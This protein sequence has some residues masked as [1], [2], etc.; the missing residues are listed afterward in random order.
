MTDQTP[1]V[2]AK[3]RRKPA[4]KGLGTDPLD[5]IATPAPVAPIKPTPDLSTRIDP[6]NDLTPIA[7]DDSRTWETVSAA[8]ALNVL[9]NPITV[10]DE[11]YVIRY[12]NEAAYKMFELIEADIRRDLPHFRAREVVGKSVD[13]FHKNPAHQRRIMDGMTE[14][15]NGKFTV[16]GKHLGFRATP[17]FGTSG[18]LA[19]VFVEWKDLTAELEA[20]ASLDQ[21]LQA[22][23]DMSEAHEN[24][25][26]SHFINLDALSSELRSVAE[27]ANQMV[28]GHIATK[29]KILACMTEFANGNLDA[30]VEKFSGE[31]FFINDAIEAIRT[32]MKNVKAEVNKLTERTR[33]MAE[34]HANGIISSAIDSSDMTEEFAFV[35]QSTNK[36]VQQ[37]IETKKKILACVGQFAKGNF[38]APLEKFSGERFFINDTV[39]DIRGAFKKVTAEIERFC[40]A[41]DSGNLAIDIDRNGFDGSYRNIVDQM[42]N[43]LVSLNK[44][45]TTATQQVAQVAITVDQMSQ[46]SQSLA[47]NSQIA[48]S[49]VD[50]VSSSTEETSIQVK[51][52]ATAADAAAKLVGST[53]V[54]A[55]DG[56]QKITDM[57]A[58]MEGI[59]VSSQD[60]AKIIKVIDEIA[61][62]TN[63]L[64]LN[65]A[66]E[67]A[68]AGQHGRGFAVVAQEV[69]NLAGRSA[70]AARETSE[71]IEDAS[72][73]VQSGVRIAGEAR[74]SFT[75]IATDIQEVQSLV[76]NIAVASEEQARGV[77]QINAGIGEVAKA[78]L[79]TSQQADELAASATEM[80]SATEIMRR[81]FDRFKLRKVTQAKAAGLGLADMSPD[82]LAQMRAMFMAELG[83]NKTAMANLAGGQNGQPRGSV[84][85]DE[86][87]F[88]NF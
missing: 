31:R 73:R 30:P 87:G 53:V 62:Q 11:N 60:I 36:M 7:K 82:L 71:L 43:A 81:D 33:A 21:L 39:E 86:R 78:A 79:A 88:G 38:D 3:P 8:D 46:S 65:A 13:V 44:T 69:R 66:V 63:L 72:T 20:K 41:L 68:R 18:K 67:A 10:A 80:Q 6:M 32:T 23:R 56:N 12:A 1:V 24:G 26:I 14:A 61:F 22:I 58:A 84:D 75:R 50:Q 47:T 77:V 4:S 48:S 54:V 83:D 29:K 85:R 70:K 35:A 15:Q 9:T 17:V 28:A 59:R 37:H 34:G 40:V 76:G 57:V 49:S 2:P 27:G 42:E 51:S 55:N 74:D 45:I 25:I 19:S 16:G 52:N 5:R 64:A